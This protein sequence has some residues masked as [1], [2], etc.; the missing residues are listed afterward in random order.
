MLEEDFVGILS[1]TSERLHGSDKFASQ[2]VV[3]NPDEVVL[4][5]DEEVLSVWGDHKV[6]GLSV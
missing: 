1:V 6:G 4:A 3:I 5:C 2:E